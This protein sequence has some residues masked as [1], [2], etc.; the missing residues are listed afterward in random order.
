[1]KKWLKN[2]NLWLL[3]LVAITCIPL[4]KPALYQ[5]HPS[6]DLMFHIQRIAAIA[7]NLENNVPLELQ[8]FWCNDQGYA[9]GAFYPSIFLVPFAL[10]YNLGLNLDVCWK[11]LTLSINF[12]TVFVG[13]YSFKRIFKNDRMAWVAIILYALAP[14]RLTDVYLRCALGESLSMMFLPLVAD[15]LYNVFKQEDNR[16]WVRMGLAYAGVCCSHELSLF[17]VVLFTVVYCLIEWRKTFTKDVFK[18]LLKATIL[19][20]TLC[21]FFLI[22]MQEFSS[23]NSLKM[24][25]EWRDVYPESVYEWQLFSFFEPVF[26][27]SA[28]LGFYGHEMPFYI[29]WPLLCGLILLPYVRG[30]HKED[31]WHT[32][33]ILGWLSLWMTSRYFPYDKL[34]KIDWTNFLIIKVQYPWRFEMMVVLFLA[35]LTP[36]A[37]SY[38]SDVRKQKTAIMVAVFAIGLGVAHQ[39]SF[40]KHANYGAIK[41]IDDLDSSNFMGG[42]FL[43]AGFSYHDFKFGVVAPVPY[44]N[45]ISNYHKNGLN[46]QVDV[47]NPTNQFQKL[48]LP[49]TYY[50]EYTAQDMKTQQTFKVINNQNGKLA[51]VVPKNYEGTIQV[52]YDEPG[53]F[54]VCR[55]ISTLALLAVLARLTM[56]RSKA[57]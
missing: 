44:K 1:M 35:M 36:I 21:L 37:I 41:R 53:Y 31:Q 13:Y 46:I 55:M 26:G 15:G 5:A 10:L 16:A 9:V 49:L 39:E 34:Q 32:L 48:G 6:H 3:V 4:M 42:E 25:Y 54:G 50:K 17:F 23:H 28:H 29:G 51:V 56:K 11:L 47:K 22:P 27:G 45:E 7:K 43:P 52:Y 12:V 57:I 19:A 24:N 33:Y 8:M 30:W 20:L 40:M 14:Y 18:D 2:T 38:V